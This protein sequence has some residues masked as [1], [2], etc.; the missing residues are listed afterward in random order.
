MVG[1]AVAAIGGGIV[2]IAPS[3]M[4]PLCVLASGGGAVAGVVLYRQYLRTRPQP[5]RSQPGQAVMENRE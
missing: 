5:L 1:G 4:Q 2:G 3:V